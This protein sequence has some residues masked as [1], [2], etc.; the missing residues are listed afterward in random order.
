MRSCGR[1]RCC[2]RS[3]RGQHAVRGRQG[4]R[5]TTRST[6]RAGRSS[7]CMAGPWI[8]A[9]RRRYEPIFAAR[10]GWRRIYPDLPGMG[11]RRRRTGRSQ[12]DS[13]GTAG[14]HRRVCRESALCSPGLRWRLSGAR[15]RG[16]ADQIAG[17][18]CA[19]LDGRRRRAADIAAIPP[20]AQGRTGRRARAKRTALGTYWSRRSD[21]IAARR[22]RKH[23]WPAG[24]EGGD[25]DRDPIPRDP[26]RYGFSFDCRN[27]TG[28]SWSPRW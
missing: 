14:L 2:P 11:R 28:L 9:S 13:R 24:H 5:S 12:D 18:C 8:T 17:C 10:P 27:W 4:R 1:C 19:C 6:A 3:V 23:R 16:I 22:E 25:A 20:V 7:S 26:K 15:R 21:L